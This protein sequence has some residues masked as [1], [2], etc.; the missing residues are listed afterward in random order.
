MTIG[1]A[2]REITIGVSCPRLVVWNEVAK[3]VLMSKLTVGITPGV[4]H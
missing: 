1:K 3:L 4:A 2:T